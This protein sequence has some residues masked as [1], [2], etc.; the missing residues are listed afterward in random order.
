[1]RRRSGQVVPRTTQCP[2]RGKGSE[3][4]GRPQQ[5]LQLRAANS[6]WCAASPSVFEVVSD[7]LTGAGNLYAIF[8]ARNGKKNWYGWRARSRMI[9]CAVYALPAREPRTLLEVSDSVVRA[10]RGWPGN[11]AE[12]AFL[13]RE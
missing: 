3:L 4:E 12:G 10:E 7:T 13:N 6:R 8:S 2:S 5:Y 11:F 1:M 9:T